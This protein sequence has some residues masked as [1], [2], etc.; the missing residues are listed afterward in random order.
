NQMTTG[1]GRGGAT[2]MPRKRECSNPSA[3]LTGNIEHNWDWAGAPP[4][5]RRSWMSRAALLPLAPQYTAASAPQPGRFLGDAGEATARSA[6]LRGDES[7]LLQTRLDS[8]QS[9][10]VLARNG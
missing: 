10:A 2:V 4:R 6:L 1:V 9:T 7:K 5:I 8:T 3:R